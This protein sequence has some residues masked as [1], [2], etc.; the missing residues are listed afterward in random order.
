MRTLLIQ[1]DVIDT[2][3]FATNKT[4]V[5]AKSSIPSRPYLGTKLEKIDEVSE[6]TTRLRDTSTYEQLMQNELAS[7]VQIEDAEQGL[8]KLIDRLKKHEV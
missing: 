5:K 4:P 8:R 3:V 1:N 7:L 2:P 6:Q